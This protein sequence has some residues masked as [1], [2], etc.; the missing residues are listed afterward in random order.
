[1]PLSNSGAAWSI[2]F[3]AS[4][5]ARH[6]ILMAESSCRKSETQQPLDIPTPQCA[7]HQSH[8]LWKN[9]AGLYPRHPGSPSWVVGKLLSH[10]AFTGITEYRPQGWPLLQAD[11]AT[12][13]NRSIDQ[14][15][16]II[17]DATLTDA[18]LDKLLHIDTRQS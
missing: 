5:I 9:L 8:R 14:W 4:L 18:I 11:P 13:K 12:G 16:K 10:L 6:T 15:H 17:G 2:F 3:D 7:D 1:M